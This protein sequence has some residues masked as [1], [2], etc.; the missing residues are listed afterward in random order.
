VEFDDFAVIGYDIVSVVNWTFYTPEV[1]RTVF[2][3]IIRNQLPIVA[4]SYPRRMES[5]PYHYGNLK[6]HV[7]LVHR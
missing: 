7:E 1:E 5:H 2:L 6:T 4:A 3:H